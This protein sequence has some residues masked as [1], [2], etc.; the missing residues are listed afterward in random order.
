VD[1]GNDAVVRGV[2][3][4]ASLN[5]CYVA[6]AT[7]LGCGGGLALAERTALD[8][9]GGQLTHV[10]ILDDDAVVPP[11]ALPG[12]IDEMARTGADAA[13]PMIVGPQ[14]RIGWFPGLLDADTFRAIRNTHT[15]AEFLATCGT[16][17]IRFSWSTGVSLLVARR[18]ID[19]LGVHRDDYWVRG[20]DL[21]FSL[22][23]THRGKGI[24]VPAVTV[25]H[26]PPSDESSG[27]RVEMLKQ[28][29]ML[30]NIAYTGV[31]LSHGRCLLRTIPGN[32]WRFARAW[33][34][35]HAITAAQA[36]WR[37]AVLGRP[38]GRGG[39]RDA[40]RRVDDLPSRGR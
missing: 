35:R 33:P 21:E 9:F 8:R 34:A 7:N 23:I 24:F 15:P 5:T 19:K 37:G 13:C 26:L 40:S 4:A 30:Q 12:L 29:A 25:Q 36:L 1:N 27:G 14:G 20:E 28:A 31:Y 2:V 10:W 17:P 39:T 32:V 11:D 22:R 16:E 3:A 38:A 18:A 6:S